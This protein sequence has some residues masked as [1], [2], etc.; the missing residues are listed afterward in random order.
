MLG[1]VSLRRLQFLHRSISP[2]DL[3]SRPAHPIFDLI[4]S[5]HLSTDKPK[6]DPSEGRHWSKNGVPEM[7]VG[8][9]ILI[10]LGIDQAI[11]YFE[12]GQ[13]KQVIHLLQDT[14]TASGHNTRRTD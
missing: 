1:V 6:N 9:T 14:T 10:L 8:C 2:H 5:K 3:V 7:I 11:H 12:K 4:R 13:R